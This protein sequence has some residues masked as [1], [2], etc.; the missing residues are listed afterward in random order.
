MQD[1]V[2]IL[3]PSCEQHILIKGFKPIGPSDISHI[4]DKP[5]SNVAGTLHAILR[6]TTIPLML[7]TTG[8]CILNI[9]NV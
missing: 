7:C 3:S 8:N 1:F 2:K 9:Q 4:K 6:A 5:Q